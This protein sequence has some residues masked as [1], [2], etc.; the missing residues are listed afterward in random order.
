MIKCDLFDVLE[1]ISHSRKPIIRIERLTNTE[2]NI[3]TF[4][5]EKQRDF[6]GLLLRN[7][8]QDGV[9]ELDMAKFS[10]MLASKYGGVHAAQQAL[11]NVEGIQKVFVDFQQ[12][13]YKE[14]VA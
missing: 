11:G 6:I 3:Y 9:D 1:D 5:N 7:Y 8:V 13:F 14:N 12:Y 4:L 2:S 10:T